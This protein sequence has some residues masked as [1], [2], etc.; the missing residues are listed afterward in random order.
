MNTIKTQHR[1]KERNKKI[2]E[3]RKAHVSG[4]YRLSSDVGSNSETILSH[5]NGS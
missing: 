5:I 2:M 4:V 3:E 1:F